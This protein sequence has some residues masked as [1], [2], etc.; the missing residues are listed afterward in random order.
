MTKKKGAEAPCVSSS[1]SLLVTDLAECNGC[2]I[3]QLSE[4][5]AGPFQLFLSGVVATA[6]DIGKDG[7]IDLLGRQ[8]LDFETLTTLLKW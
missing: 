5:A 7:L 6:A 2:C 1:L 4:E 8:T 3:L